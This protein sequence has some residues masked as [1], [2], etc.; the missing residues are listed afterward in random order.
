MLSDLRSRSGEK[1]SANRDE[2]VHSLLYTRLG[3]AM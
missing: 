3:E 2:V 1:S